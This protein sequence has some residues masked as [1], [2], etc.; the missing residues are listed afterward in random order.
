MVGT[1]N[2]VQTVIVTELGWT[3]IETD[4]RKKKKKKTGETRGN[5]KTRILLQVHI[6]GHAYG[7]SPKEG[8]SACPI[9]TV[10]S[11][12]AN[13]ASKPSFVRSTLVT[14][15]NIPCCVYV[16]RNGELTN[17][18]AYAPTRHKNTDS[19]MYRRV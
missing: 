9:N 16:N 17:G 8:L 12:D 15:A 5:R 7:K 13:H 6:S 14:D 11:R 3:T 19:R 10:L 18:I 2:V 1:Q 4:E